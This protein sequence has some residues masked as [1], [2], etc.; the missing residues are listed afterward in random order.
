[1]RGALRRSTC[2]VVTE[3][4]NSSA[5]TSFLECFFCPATV[6]KAIR[7]ALVVGPILGLINHFDLVAGGG[8]TGTRLFKICFTFLVPFCVSG[9][10]SATTMMVEHGGASSA[11]AGA[12]A[13]LEKD[14]C[15]SQ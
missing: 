4:T 2:V 9:Y 5:P 12:P 3:E 11:S 7:V 15:H 8:L 13:R 14:Y 1:M 6:N 10:S